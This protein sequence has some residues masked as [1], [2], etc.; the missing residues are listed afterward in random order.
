MGLIIGTSAGKKTQKIIHSPVHSWS[1]L[2][3][4][5]LI[6]MVKRPTKGEGI[7]TNR[8]KLVEIVKVKGNSGGVNHEMIMFQTVR[9]RR[10]EG[11]RI[12]TLDIRKVNSGN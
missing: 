4:I 3:I 1:M 6:Q 10:K 9:R 2:R 8:K 12:R 11:S 5:F 7:L